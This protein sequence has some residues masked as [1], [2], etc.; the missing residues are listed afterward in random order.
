MRA[1]MHTNN[2]REQ[3]RDESK[4]YVNTRF[5]CVFATS[6]REDNVVSES[7]NF[8]CRTWQ[9]EKCVFYNVEPYHTKGEISSVLPFQNNLGR[10]D[11]HQ[12]SSHPC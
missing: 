9:I 7:L 4:I 8:L 10:R 6:Y 3:E 5:S 2:E 12:D 11:P 1:H